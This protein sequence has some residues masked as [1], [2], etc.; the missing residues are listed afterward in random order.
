MVVRSHVS[1]AA[2]LLPLP[3]VLKEDPKSRVEKLG[4]DHE[5]VV[6]K[7]YGNPAF[8]IWRTFWRLSRGAREFRN[9]SELSAAG[10]PVVR[11]LSWGETRTLS[12]VR[13]SFLVTEWLE[14]APS[15][16]T[17][18]SSCSDPATRRVL[19]RKYG[20]L[21]RRV[22]LAGFLSLTPH[23]RNVLVRGGARSGDLCFCDQPLTLRFRRSIYGGRLAQIDLY[24]VAFTVMRRL[25]LSRAERYRLLLAYASG[26]RRMARR[27]WSRLHP[28]R[29]FTNR[30]SRSMVYLLFNFF[31]APFLPRRASPKTA[32]DASG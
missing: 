18:L 25:E 12:F 2:G 8:S 13:T 30:A 32:L 3:E 10:I 19:V 9:L 5:A 29:S 1:L 4:R 27:I 6:R 15:L 22:H 26:E 24:S 7:S 20:E 11:P 21:V 23:P 16:K 17:F 31:L 14:A 28:R